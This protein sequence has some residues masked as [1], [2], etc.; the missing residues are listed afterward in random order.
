VLPTRGL[1]HGVFLLSHAARLRKRRNLDE[2]LEAARARPTFMAHA[3]DFE[4]IAFRLIELGLAS[5]GDYV[6]LDDTLA[7]LSDQ[8]DRTTL[9]A[10]ARILFL[11]AAPFW[12]SLAVSQGRVLREYVPKEDLE[13]LRWIEPE[14]DQFLMDC[15]ASTATRE[16][17]ALRKR[18]GAAAELFV[19]AALK[20]AGRN[21]AHVAKISDA[22]GYDIEC[23]GIGSV[24][25]IEVKAASRNTQESFHL[26]RNE[27]DKSIL[28]GKEWRLVQIVFS[29]RA[30]VADGLDASHVDQIRELRFGA[31]QEL[32]SPD[33]LAFRWTES[34]LITAPNG[35]WRSAEITLDPDFATDGFRNVIVRGVS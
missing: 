6:A 35:A 12:I 21:P 5:I 28:Y 31:L 33:T 2:W 4:R 27:F 24:D 11:K 17:N 10:I 26:S 23:A 9:V 13:D 3:L 29:N 34:A 20:R 25:R 8:A 32:A 30:F 19:I 22:Y 16:Q 18:I 14:L 7:E 15:H 1:C